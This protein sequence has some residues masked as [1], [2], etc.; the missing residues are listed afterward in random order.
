MFNSDIDLL[1]KKRKDQTCTENAFNMA[2][3]FYLYY[4]NFSSHAFI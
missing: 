1:C 2:D 3:V 4:N